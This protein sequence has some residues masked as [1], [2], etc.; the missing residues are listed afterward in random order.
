MSYRI[1]AGLL[2]LWVGLLACDGT[3]VGGA[4]LEQDDQRNPFVRWAPEDNP[5]LLDGNLSYKLSSLPS[6][7]SVDQVPWPG[8]YWP[9]YLD[10]INHRWAGAGTESAAAKYGRAF[11]VS[12]VEK[13]VSSGFGIGMCSSCRTCFS[14]S[15][16]KSK[17]EACARRPG[18]TLGRCIPTWWGVCHA[19]A[20][21]AILEPE[22]A[23]PV[24]TGGVTFNVN[25]IKALI[26]LAYNKT[27]YKFVSLRCNEN[28]SKG[29]VR[30][31]AYGRPTGDDVECRD[32][33]PG[34]F[35]VVLA[36]YVGIRRES[37][38][39]D[40][41]FDY[42]VWNQ[43]VLSYKVLEE[44]PVSAAEA[45]KLVGAS[46]STYKF[47]TDAKSFH[48]MKVQVVWVKEAEAAP[49]TDRALVPQVTKYS[50]V[51]TYSYVLELDGQGKIIGGEWLG[52][53]KKDHPD[54]LWVPRAVGEQQVAGVRYADVKKLVDKSATAAPA[55]APAPSSGHLD[56]SGSVAKGEA[57][58]FTLAVKKGKQV[59]VRTQAA[60]DID[61]FVRLGQKPT[62]YVYDARS[63][64]WTGDEEIK[65]VPPQ[66]G[67]LHIM[68]YGYA[69][70][71]FRLTTSDS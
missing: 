23:G 65:Y 61:L 19:W 30:Y 56:E 70:S 54:F 47:N 8:S 45:N 27:D 15:Q 11:G 63:I 58:Y 59:V 67:T 22:P 29:E 41:V 3:L 43:P 7:G 34:T 42:E 32:T 5:G 57:R 37:F 18:E 40:R 6:S 44:Q 69:A 14:H 55:P 51:D 38:V 31:D 24:T 20:P 46:G 68:V 2:A 39:E 10:S 49:A 66:D 36:N 4:A 13:Q 28:A 53:S 52:T 62:V 12:G 21:A 64:G 17:V 1:G 26:T 35:H 16:C 71:S 50:G 9:A 25:D 60:G 33:N 48:R